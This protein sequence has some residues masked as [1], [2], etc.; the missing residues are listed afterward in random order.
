MMVARGESPAF[1]ATPTMTF[2]LENAKLEQRASFTPAG[3]EHVIITTWRYSIN[4]QV[5]YK[6]CVR[7]HFTGNARNCYRSL[8]NQGWQ[9]A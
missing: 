6:A 8:V 4:E 1:I 7:K 3:A 2:T 5:W 9:P